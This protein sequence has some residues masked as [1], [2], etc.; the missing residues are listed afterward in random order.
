MIKLINVAKAINQGDIPIINPVRGDDLIDKVFDGVNIFLL[1]AGI[2]AAIYL[3]YGGVLY[4]TAGGDAEK[5]TKGRTAVINAIIGIVI[6]LL[7][8]VVMRYV[9]GAF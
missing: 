5:A 6:I 8:L 9:T 1:F 2:L 7:S 4:I 3:I